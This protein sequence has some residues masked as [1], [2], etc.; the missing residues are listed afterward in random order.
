M[1]CVHDF[2]Q[3]LVVCWR[4]TDH[5]RVIAAAM[6]FQLHA[7]DTVMWLMS[8][9][10]IAARI[11][12][13]PDNRP[14]CVAPGCEGVDGREPRDTDHPGTA[15]PHCSALLQ[16]GRVAVSRHML[17]WPRRPLDAGNWLTHARTAP[18]GSRNNFQQPLYQQHSHI[19]LGLTRTYIFTHCL[20]TSMPRRQLQRSTF[21]SSHHYSPSR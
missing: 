21:H 7:G 15:R 18:H 6:Y 9:S 20:R 11:L 3:D 16:P 13:G 10:Y 2:S 1:E 12:C 14:S 19:Y 5:G 4:K 8:R 17:T